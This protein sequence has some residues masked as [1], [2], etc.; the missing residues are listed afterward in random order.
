[1]GIILVLNGI[2]KNSSFK[3]CWLDHYIDIL[4]RFVLSDKIIS[5]LKTEMLDFVRCL[6]TAWSS[7][8]WKKWGIIDFKI[9]ETVIL[10]LCCW[11]PHIR[12]FKSCLIIPYQIIETVIL[13]IYCWIPPNWQFKSGCIFPYQIIESL[14]VN[15]CHVGDRVDLGPESH[16]VLLLSF[17]KILEKCFKSFCSRLLVYS[18]HAPINCLSIRNIRIMFSCEKNYKL[19]NS[20]LK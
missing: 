11:I 2:T 18:N 19:T 15:F 20:D 14:V 1:M 12:K 5:Q 6:L 16:A 17:I 9:I 10:L 8:K 7:S 3:I 13:L 4:F